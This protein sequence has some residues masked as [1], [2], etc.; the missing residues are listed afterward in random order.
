MSKILVIQDN[1]ADLTE[2]TRILENHKFQTLTAGT[3]KKAV[4]LLESDY[5]ID[6]V[7]TSRILPQ[8]SGFDLLKHIKQTTRF[9]N[10]PVFI[11]CHNFNSDIAI[12]AMN[13][14]AGD[15]LAFPI[16]E[17]VLIPKLEKA[18]AFGKFNIL[19][20]D[21]D[22]MIL[23]YLKDMLN[24]ERF[25]PVT[26]SCG[27]DALKILSEKNIDAVVS[28]INMP[29][30]SGLELLIEIKYQYEHIPVILIT[31]YGG[32]FSP[33]DIIASGADGYF[34]KPFRNVELTNTLRYVLFN[35]RRK[36]GKTAGINNR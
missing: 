6:L 2:I 34:K 25:K 21:D 16:N 23:D 27:E 17:S 22:P 28:D 18:L 14:G 12:N 32:D 13:L 3:F 24:L 1:T 10:I 8:H 31:G 30:M 36:L 7:I 15:L 33:T 5:E 29:G 20:V 11:T 19:V 9:Q 26:A 4:T 35:S